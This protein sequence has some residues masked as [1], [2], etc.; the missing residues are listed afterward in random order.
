[1]KSV[2]TLGGALL[3]STMF[4]APSAALA[5]QADA[6]AVANPDDTIVVRG[7]FIPEPQR[8]TAQV[9][10][11]VTNEDLQR[12][13]DA[14]A[15]IALTRVSGLS[16]VGGRF[17]YV[18]GLGDR[19]SAA[20]LNG[21]PLPSPEPLRRTVPLD[22][23]PSGV[24]DRIAVQKTYSANYQGEFGGG[25]IDLRTLRRPLE[26]FFNVS[27]SIGYNTETTNEDGLFHYGSDD[28]WTGWDGGLRQLPDPLA[29]VVANG[30]PLSSLPDGYIENA[31]E[32][33]VNSPLTVIQRGEVGPSSSFGAEGGLTLTRGDWDIGLIGAAGYSQGWET[34]RA[35]R[36][37]VLGDIIGNE[38]QTTETALD[39]QTN[40]LGS[41]SVDNGD[42]LLQATAF[43][44]HS[45]SKESQIDTG[46]D[47]NAPGATGQVFDESTGWYERELSMFQLAGEHFFG[48]FE[49]RWRGSVAQATRDAPY[50]RSLRRFPDPTT[51][52]PGYEEANNYSIRFSY[53]TD[54]LTN[55]GIDLQ[56]TFNLNDGRE[57]VIMGGYD[58]SRTERE[59]DFLALRFAGGNSLP[60]DVK[61]ARPDY[62]FGPD[63]IDP[64]RFVLQEIVTP[65]DS[66]SA[67][68]D[69]DAFY[70]QADFDITNFIRATV[71]VRYE[72]GEERV[73]TFNRF[74][75]LGAGSAISEDY[76]LPAL[77]IT[78]NFADDLQLRAGYSETIARPQF[79]E[80]ARSSFFDPESERLYR[81]NSGL[82]D[83]T[84]Q[85]FDARLEYYMGRDQFITGAIFYKKIENPIEEV[86][87]STSTFVFE[88]TFINSPEA[89]VQGVELEF[90]RYFNLPIDNAFLNDRDF[91]FSVN[92]TYTDS[93]VTAGANDM[94]FDPI[95]GTPVAASRF[96]LDGS[97]L[98]GTP[99]HI[100]NAQLGWESDVEQL[101]L[102]L[103]W[104]DERVLQRGL[105][106]P[107]AELPDVIEDP[108]FQ[109][110][111][112][113][114]RDF[115]V[116]GQPITLGLSARNLLNEDHIE[117]QRNPTIGVTNFN[118]YERGTTFSASLTARF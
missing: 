20:L 52:V 28:D 87:F 97:V 86:Q 108:G 78:W 14:D 59:Y 35:T 15:A 56:R 3:A 68:L 13:G 79:R 83:S 116:Q 9:A 85:N 12:S 36:Q 1:M 118:T 2:S 65:N 34:Q 91:R 62:L 25:L 104:V 63:N 88:T 75:L 30:I 54:D 115:D 67:N 69:V 117:F 92:Y 72:E 66:Y 22:L 90:R 60:D 39:V 105:T 29:Y 6:T 71:G 114:S 27:S 40:A 5:Q 80:L 4:L 107:G 8:Q 113:Y 17:A 16:V 26:N 110:D 61:V 77:T 23:F 73:Q 49:V 32:S 10:S 57:L 7:Q 41:V 45:T 81:G 95:T 18:R 64:N 101:T 84:I 93:E 21:S 111:L 11:F 76:V 31:G 37:F 100:V 109:L 74:G 55:F 19:Y 50:E 106:Q 70:L 51:G 112:T 82:V 89:T 33:L 103:N 48:D 96:G 53:L 94:V 102:L 24:L 98:Q 44:V 46:R 99:E 38:F 43:W 47:F 58:R 42:H